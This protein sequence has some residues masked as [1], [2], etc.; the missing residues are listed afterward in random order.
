MSKR[1]ARFLL[2][3]ALVLACGLALVVRFG[4]SPVSAQATTPT[5]EV[6][7]LKEWMA[8]GHAK[9]DS[10]AFTHW[11]EATPKEIPVGCAKC[12]SSIGFQDFVGADGSAVMKVDKAAPTGTVISCTT[13]HNE[14]T[15]KLSSVV[16]P[17]GAEI[18]GLG[19]E[20]VCMTCHQ[21]AASMVQVDESIKKSGATDEDKVPAPADPK[22]A[23]GFTNIHY[24]AAS[25]ARYGK[26]VSGGYQYTGKAY[27]AL[28]DH[29]EGVQA[30]TDCHNPHSLELEVAKCG[31]CHTGV[32]TVEDVRKI[33]ME[34][35]TVDYD[36]DGDVKEGIYSE[37]EGMRA[38]LY[39]GMQEYAKTVAGKAIVYDAATYPYFFVDTNGNGKGD[40]D[41]L[42]FPNAYKD[43]TPR[44]VKAAFNYQASIKD[45][46]AYAHGGKYIIEL[47][48]DSTESLNEKLT[49]KVDLS[50]AHRIDAG[51]FAG[52]EEAFRHWDEEGDVPGGCVKCHTGM[53][54]PEFLKEGVTTSMKPSNGLMCETCHNDLTK[55]TRYEVKS[56]P[57]P[58]GA[59]LTF[60]DTKMDANL[61]LECHQGRESTVSM[62][63][64]LAAATDADAVVEKLGFKNV[65]YFAAGA[66]LFGTEAKGVYEYTGKTYAGRFKHVEGKFE[67]CTDCHD[68]HGLAPKV[69]E[70]KTCHGV[71]DPTAIR[72]NTK[73]DVDGDGDVKEGLAGE[74]D[75]MA[76]AVYAAMQAYAKDVVKKPIVYNAAA[77]PY[78]FDDANGNGKVDE[79]EKAYASWTPRLLKAAYNYQYV[80]KDP[81]A[82]VH[83]GKYILQVLYDTLEDLGAKTKVDLTKMKRPQ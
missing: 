66:T 1:T 68:T 56:V 64:A 42:A 29:V 26:L 74:V 13:C 9:A 72:M 36:G 50:K 69:S 31:T 28:F 81:G 4:T 25:V 52:S 12:H 21:G 61:C 54:L 77:Y 18:K 8:S 17:S 22:N 79:G 32:K 80:Q 67:T 23:L 45:P 39:K 46:G 33:R 73:D 51:H 83:N 76:K 16:F 55:F 6:P 47:L 58:S 35:S 82:F 15:A 70:C 20:A 2:I 48:Y 41:E 75:G 78:F 11:D 71:D 37:V 62:N 65:H 60:G 5:V 7:F 49:T 44:L 10:A 43:W 53:G 63:K 57:F 19:R 14:G 59:S 24:F 38:L 27:D 34:S 40:K 30:C 3:G